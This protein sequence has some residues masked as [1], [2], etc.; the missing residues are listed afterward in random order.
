MLKQC[1]DLLASLGDEYDVE[2]CKV[3][4]FCSKIIH[5]NMKT[6]SV[7]DIKIADRIKLAIGVF[8]VYNLKRLEIYANY[9]FALMRLK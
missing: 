1:E 5:T 7:I 4:L 8:S 3:A 6:R 9:K 2:R